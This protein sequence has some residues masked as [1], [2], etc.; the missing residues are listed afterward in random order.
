M[1]NFKC[2]HMYACIRALAIMVLKSYHHSILKKVLHRRRY[3]YIFYLSCTNKKKT[4]LFSTQLKY[5]LFV[6]LFFLFFLSNRFL[7]LSLDRWSSRSLSCEAVTAQYSPSPC[8]LISWRIEAAQNH[9]KEKE[10]NSNAIE[11]ES[12]AKTQSESR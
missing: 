11:I 10:L 8:S 2:I 12:N 1:F 6:D 9:Y 4:F 7:S 5:Y 3:M